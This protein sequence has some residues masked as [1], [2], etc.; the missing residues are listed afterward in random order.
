MFQL[1]Q[2]CETGD[3]H[4]D[5]SQHHLV[6]KYQSFYRT[7]CLHYQCRIS[8]RLILILKRI[9]FAIDGGCRQFPSHI[10]TFKSILSHADLCRVT[11]VKNTAFHT[12][13][14]VPFLLTG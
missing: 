1:L 11:D 14:H 13:I 10:T 12:L 8:Q 7:C 4:D 6:D 9:T 5:M 3:A 2:A